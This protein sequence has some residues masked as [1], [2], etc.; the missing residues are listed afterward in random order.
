MAQSPVVLSAPTVTPTGMP[1]LQSAG[2]FTSQDPLIYRM[3]YTFDS[4][5]SCQDVCYGEKYNVLGLG[6]GT[7]CYCG[8]QLPAADTKVDDSQCNTKCAGFPDENC[9]LRSI[10]IT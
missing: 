8:N 5:G 4:S 3:K 9:K 1:S 7:D 2:C 10:D 6:N